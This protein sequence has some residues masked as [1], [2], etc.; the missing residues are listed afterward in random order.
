[1]VTID[2]IVIHSAV[3]NNHL[4]YTDV[5]VFAGDNFHDAAD[6]SYRNLV[7][8]NLPVPDIIFFHAY[9]PAIVSRDN[10]C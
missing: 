6:A 5:K 1:M 3:N 2:G 10:N 9:T 7:W 8:K 4:S